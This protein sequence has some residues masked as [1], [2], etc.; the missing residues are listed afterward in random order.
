MATIA[1][2]ENIALAY[3]RTEED[4]DGDLVGVLID[5][6][7]V[8]RGR[9]MAIV[10]DSGSGKSSLLSILGA[11]KGINAAG[12]QS[13]ATL[14]LRCGRV[15]NLLAGHSPEA[16]DVAFVFQEAHLMKPLSALA[17]FE[18]G[19][20]VAGRSLTDRD[21]MSF[22]RESGL[23]V[24]RDGDDVE[25]RS[26]VLAAQ[27]V[28]Q[29][30]GGQAQ[31]IAVGRALATSPELLLC[32]EPTSN[33]DG[34]HG[35]AVMRR[36]KAWIDTSEGTAIWV[37]HNLEQ[38]AEFADC[39][40]VSS[41]GRLLSA[42]G[43]PFDLV[44]LSIEQRASCLADRLRQANELEHM[45]SAHFADLDIQFRSVPF[46][47]KYSTTS[48]HAPRPSVFYQVLGFLSRCVVSDMFRGARLPPDG[49]KIEPPKTRRR[50][51]QRRGILSAFRQI[52][53]FSSWGMAVA[54]TIGLLTAYTGLIAC[55]AF[56]QYF[57]E[58][59]KQPTMSHF[60]VSGEG[61]SMSMRA[62]GDL[63]RQLA[64][65]FP[66]DDQTAK[67]EVFGRWRDPFTTISLPDD[68]ACIETGEGRIRPSVL[69][70]NSGEPLFRGL[71][72]TAAAK[73]R[74]GLPVAIV[75]EDL[76]GSLKAHYAVAEL[77]DIC[78]H[79]T[80]PVHFHIGLAVPVLPGT[81][82]LSYH[83][84]IEEDVF[85]Q[86]FEANPPAS[87][88]SDRGR[89]TY[90]LFT[91]AAIYFD[92][93][94]AEPLLCEFL[95]DNDD[96]VGSCE[97]VERRVGYQADGDALRQLSGFLTVADVTRASIGGILFVFLLSIITSAVLAL[98]S[99]IL[100]NEKFLCILK[101]FRYRRRHLFFIVAL[102]SVILV[103]IGAVIVGSGLAVAQFAA[104]PQIAASF[105]IPAAWIG[106]DPVLFATAVAALLLLA[107]IVCF[108]V[109]LKWW[110]DNCYVGDKLQSI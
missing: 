86:A 11:L 83:I 21:F 67:P 20:L 103:A 81:G 66:A 97:E 7:H 69:T 37:T 58:K 54:L 85:L 74:T 75:T 72:E 101:A 63:R 40:V 102:Q 38:A 104:V 15:V 77:N 106:F 94:Y 31:R 35:G 18:A 19:A 17:N 12:R 105:E 6:L 109:I 76:I 90:P 43:L 64:K 55:R 8:P 46:N 3:R 62:I 89:L 110:R 65:R 2:L 92:P 70:V 30:S 87:G 42:D 68:G 14:T 99:F 45:S 88:F 23:V 53:G 13:T 71:F 28:S 1:H 9:L 27:P 80:S 25:R 91:N 107:W 24:N 50:E 95:D 59:L 4:A 47:G 16:G 41:H 100:E 98:N 96:A 93:V 60:V 73:S 61:A 49:S 56:D 44:G 39:F 82:K 22:A 29:L 78:I 10:G 52:A 36:I 57:D 5:R 48:R 108:F 32:D 34:K 84:A 79:L 51:V 33:L 26:Q